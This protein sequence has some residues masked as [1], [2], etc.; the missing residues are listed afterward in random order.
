MR[1]S[2]P[3]LRRF[4]DTRER[5]PL[6][7]RY[8]TAAP[9]ACLRRHARLRCAIAAAAAYYFDF[10]RRHYA[11]Y[12]RRYFAPCRFSCHACFTA[13]H[14]H[15]PLPHITHRLPAS[16]RPHLSPDYIIRRRFFSY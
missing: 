11:A 13:I 10:C 3:V 7:S 12:F 15:L 16:R 8:V 5:L 1:Q 14:H 6:F 2:A 4:D 9:H